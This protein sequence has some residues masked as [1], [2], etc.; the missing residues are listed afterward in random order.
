MVP[1]GP[2]P[3]ALHGV[4][5]SL[6]STCVAFWGCLEPQKVCQHVVCVFGGKGLNVLEGACDTP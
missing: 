5:G 3:G 6:E 4:S 2:G 1:A